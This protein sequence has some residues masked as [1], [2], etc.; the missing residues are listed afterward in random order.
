[1]PAIVSH[2]P[3]LW[4]HP[5]RATGQGTSERLTASNMKMMQAGKF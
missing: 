3:V 4:K 5:L 2:L 1:M